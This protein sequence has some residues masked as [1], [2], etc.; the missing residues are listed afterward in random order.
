MRHTAKTKMESL[1]EFLGYDGGNPGRFLEFL[2]EAIGLMPPDVADAMR[3]FYLSGEGQRMD[4]E[5]GKSRPEDS[6]FYQFTERGREILK[7]LI[8]LAM[9]RPGFVKKIQSLYGDEY[10]SAEVPVFREELLPL[11]VPDDFPS[12]L[13]EEKA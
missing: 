9:E 4:P 7:T 1:K 12:D 2:Q 13:I 11:T 6:R 5:T 10:T 3:R 8:I